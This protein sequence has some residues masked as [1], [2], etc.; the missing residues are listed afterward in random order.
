VQQN[1]VRLLYVLKEKKLFIEQVSTKCKTLF[2]SNHSKEE[3]LT[4]K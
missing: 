3:E 1:I 2:S 4:F